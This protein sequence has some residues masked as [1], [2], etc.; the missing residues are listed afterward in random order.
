MHYSMPVLSVLLLSLAYK[1]T[2]TMFIWD[3][4]GDES[5]DDILHSSVETFILFQAV[6]EFV[7]TF[8]FFDTAIKS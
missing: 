6:F 7:S 3:F 4:Y 8:Q 2:M 5:H 1:V